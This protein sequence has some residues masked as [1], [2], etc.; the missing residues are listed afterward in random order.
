[1]IKRIANIVIVIALAGLMSQTAFA[2]YPPHGT[3]A[4]DSGSVALMLSAAIGGLAALK[5]FWR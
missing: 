5:R 3:G 1:M 2:N 4:P